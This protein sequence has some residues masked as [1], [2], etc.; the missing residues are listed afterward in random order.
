LQP[1]IEAICCEAL[2][3][4]LLHLDATPRHLTCRLADGH[5][6]TYPNPVDYLGKVSSDATPIL[7]GNRHGQLDG[8]AI[9]V[10]P[11]GQTWLVDFAQAGSGPLIYDAVTLETALKFTLLESTDLMA[12][13]E[14]EQRLSAPTDLAATIS[15]DN[16]PGDLAKAVQ[17][18]QRC[19]Q[20]VA[21]YAGLE[22]QSY[23]TGLFY[24]ALR[25][26][27]DFDP[28]THPPRRELI[29]AI[30]ALLSAAILSQ[31]LTAIT[32]QVDQ[33]PDQ[34]RQGFWVDE[35]NR[36]VWEAGRQIALTPT[37]FDLFLYLYHHA[38][39]LCTREDICQAVF[40]VPYWTDKKRRQTTEGDRIT[41]AIR[42]LRQ[43]IESDPQ[44]PQLIV[45]K[46]GIGY[47]L[48]LPPKPS[49]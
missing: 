7:C 10:A 35:T 26:V 8:N 4:N 1:H 16:L 46:R 33:L 34:A 42:R 23:L 47:K 45:T 12:L 18:I 30:H 38:G 13:L 20:L 5:I 44:R 9:L 6:V 43:A 48:M 27:A 3:N 21:L 17:A 41:T 40:G 15:A 29:S 14:M 31:R 36:A 22:I 49:S 11:Q 39:Q 37:E 32:T 2:A 25:K 28:K 24:A 19:R